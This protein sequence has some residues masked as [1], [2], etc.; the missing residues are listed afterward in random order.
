[1]KHVFLFIAIFLTHLVQGQNNHDKIIAE[2]NRLT[3]EWEGAMEYTDERDDKTVFSMPAK[4]QNEFNGKKWRYAVQ[5][6]EG[7]GEMAGGKGECTINDDGTKMNYDGVV[8]DVTE[9][10]KTG[11]TTKIVIQTKGKENR[12]KAELRRTFVISSRNF[13]ILE[14]VNFIEE[15]KGYIMRNKHVFRRPKKQ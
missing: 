11:D 10:T 4:C 12:Q 1:M 9:I 2:F 5:Y 14:E 13:S 6:D 15:N 8:W 3:G 7:S